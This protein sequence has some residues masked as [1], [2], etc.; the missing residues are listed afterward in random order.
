MYRQVAPQKRL[1]LRE[2]FVRVCKLLTKR[3]EDERLENWKE[4][5]TNFNVIK[6][7]L[8]WTPTT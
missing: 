6:E 8:S 7:T 1:K 2:S 3:S 5:L 4:E